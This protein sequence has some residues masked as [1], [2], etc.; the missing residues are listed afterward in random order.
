M[1]KGDT[2]PAE[3]VG[4]V[5]E[6]TGRRVTQL[7]SSPSH[8]HHFYFTSTSFHPDGEHLFFSSRRTGK[9]NIFSMNLKSGR[10]RQ[11]TECEKIS[12]LAACLD[13]RG[14][15]VYYWD[16]PDLK[17]SDIE[18]PE[19]RHLYTVPQG[20]RGGLLSIPDD[21]SRLVFPATPILE[22]KTQT[23]KI[24]SGMQ[25]MFERCD[26]TD[27]V[28]VPTDGSACWVAYREN[29]WASHVNVCPTDPDL[30]LYCHEGSWTMVQ[31]RMW[32]VRSDGSG[33]RPLRP[34][35]P[36]N[37]L[38]H[39]Y[40]HRDGQTVGY[41]GH[42]KEGRT[43]PIFGLINKDGSHCREYHTQRSTGHSQSSADGKMHT[44]DGAGLIC[45]IEPEDGTASFTPL[46]RHDTSGEMQIG[47]AHPIFSPDG[48][49][50]LFTSDKSGV[51][52]VYMVEV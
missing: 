49:F 50:V 30:I 12:S 38:G 33:R 39:E 51:C 32:L 10:M 13:P 11:I 8:D 9:F 31:Q 43:D 34:Q 19:E 3:M 47:H 46:A 36:Q 18:T 21:G 23:E 48:K 5:D 20:F 41:H 1:A 37:A 27:I 17:A 42:L 29:C 2:F 14:H 15:E 52:N 26:R 22:L 4:Y 7:T 16:G 24:Y 40:W 35:E 44:C 25:E 6:E 28:V 45:L